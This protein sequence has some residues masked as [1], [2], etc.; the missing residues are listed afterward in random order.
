VLVTFI[1][2]EEM[3][4]IMGINY[5]IFHLRFEFNIPFQKID[6]E[7]LMRLQCHFFYIVIKII[8]IDDCEYSI[9]LF[10]D[11]QIWPFLHLY[12]NSCPIRTFQVIF[13]TSFKSGKVFIWDAP[14]ICEKIMVKQSIFQHFKDLKF[15]L[16]VNLILYTSGRVSYL[17]ALNKTPKIFAHP[18]ETKSDPK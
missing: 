12:V 16:T 8:Q 10:Q 5:W 17:H 18:L 2:I 4:I 6:D 15:F 14:T 7:F 1:L 9:S 13:Q 11:L 3:T